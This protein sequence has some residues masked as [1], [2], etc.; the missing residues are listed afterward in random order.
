M[1]NQVVD[2]LHIPPFP[3]CYGETSP[4]EDV[5]TMMILIMIM[6]MIL[7]LRTI[8]IVI[9]DYMPLCLFVT[10]KQVQVIM[11]MMAMKK[12]FIQSHINSIIHHHTS[13][14]IS[15]SC[16]FPPWSCEE[17]RSCWAGW[18]F[19]QKDHCCSFN[20]NLYDVLFL[21]FIVGPGVIFRIAV[22]DRNLF[23]VLKRYSLLVTV[24]SLTNR[25]FDVLSSKNLRRSFL[26]HSLYGYHPS[27]RP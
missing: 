18:D 16:N 14:G 19:S 20:L 8:V 5:T 10:V 2:N 1:F 11:M 24:F 26:H 21:L 9:I 12:I 17:R 25:L 15:K 4:G 3:L 23:D 6:M 22:D 7:R 13:P 27:G